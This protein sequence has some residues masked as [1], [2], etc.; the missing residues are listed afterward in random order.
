M[1]VSHAYADHYKQMTCAKAVRIVHA[2]G[3]NQ[4]SLNIVSVQAE[5]LAGW[6][7]KGCREPAKATSTRNAC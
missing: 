5:A 2:K 7:L 1:L 4:H 6:I 3:K